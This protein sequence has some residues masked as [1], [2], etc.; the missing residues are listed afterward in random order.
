MKIKCCQTCIRRV[1]HTV[2]TAPVLYCMYLQTYI[3]P[4]YCCAYYIPTEEMK[5]TK[6]DLNTFK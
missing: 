4:F 3:N 1:T 2:L 6:N 5:K